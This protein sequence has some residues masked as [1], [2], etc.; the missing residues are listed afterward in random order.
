MKLVQLYMHKAGQVQ[1]ILVLLYFVVFGIVSC[2]KSEVEVFDAPDPI[3]VVSA[4]DDYIPVYP[5]TDA[6]MVSIKNITY[7]ENAGQLFEKSAGSARA[8]FPS[9]KG[10][11]VNAGDVTCQQ[12]PLNFESGN[13]YGYQPSTLA[14]EGIAFP[15]NKLR[16]SVSGN[17]NIP[18]MN[19]MNI[20]GF[21]TISPILDNPETIDRSQEFT[22][23]LT[24]HIQNADSVRFTITASN[25]QLFAEDWA[26][27]NSVTFSSNKLQAL[28]PGEAVIKITAFRTVTMQVNEKIIQAINQSVISKKVTIL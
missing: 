3:P 1:A 27:I 28:A 4:N 9:A 17:S 24:D 12:V 23:G 2:K 19:F 26:V 8:I 22:L 20:D 7:E 6:V 18:N 15:D 10:A 16:W 21:P 5:N 13:L 11:L 14:P 25:G